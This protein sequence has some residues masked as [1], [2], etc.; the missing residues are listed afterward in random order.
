M[1][2]SHVKEA[3]HRDRLFSPDRDFPPTEAR[4]RF[5]ILSAPRT[6][7]QML[8]SALNASR[9]AGHPQEYLN[10]RYIALHEKEFRGGRWSLDAYLADIARR[11]TSPNGVFGIKLHAGQFHQVFGK[12]PREGNTFLKSFNRW[13]L[14]YRR[15]KLD[16]AISHLLAN[17]RNIWQSESDEPVPEVRAFAA[18]DVPKVA[19][20][21]TLVAQEE[22]FWRQTAKGLGLDVLEVAY[23][24]LAADPRREIGRVLG[25][26]GVAL[27]RDQ[28]PLPTTRRLGGEGNRAFRDAFL[29][30]IGEGR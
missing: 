7:S 13:I 6:G 15:R 3:L 2:E 4:T 28:I 5:L 30:A 26:L 27:P 16:Q 23:E 29:K 11:R 22:L 1:A 10:G 24:D 14:T 19:Y 12:Q 25:H 9:L 17:E 18:D 21:L 8:C 20:H